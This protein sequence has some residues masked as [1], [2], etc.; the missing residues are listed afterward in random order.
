MRNCTPCRVVLPLA[1]LVALAGGA[2]EPVPAKDRI[3]LDQYGPTRSE[4]FLADADGKNPRKLV[5]GTNLDRT[6]L[7]ETDRTCR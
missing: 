2:N 3:Y 7:R 5:P 6:H 4:L 1:M